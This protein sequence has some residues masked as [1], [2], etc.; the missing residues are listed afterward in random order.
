MLTFIAFVAGVFLG[1]YVP[2]P[3]PVQSFVS[4]LIVKIKSLL[5]LT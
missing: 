5:G 1:W 3:A 4:G 2:Q